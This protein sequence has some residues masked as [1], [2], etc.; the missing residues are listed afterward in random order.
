MQRY[1]TSGLIFV[2]IIAT[3]WAYEIVDTLLREFAQDI[4]YIDLGV[5]YILGLIAGLTL[6]AA[7]AL[8]RR[9]SAV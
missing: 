2:A 7:L 1:T 4:T 6:G 3:F 9:Q 8:R 5:L